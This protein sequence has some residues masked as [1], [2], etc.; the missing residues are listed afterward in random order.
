MRVRLALHSD[1]D[2][3]RLDVQ[4]GGRG[5]DRAKL[6]QADTALGQHIG[7]VGMQERIALLDGQFAITS[8]PSLGTPVV[9]E[10]PLSG[11]YTVDASAEETAQQHIQRV[12]HKARLVIADDHDVSRAGIRSM[13]IISALTIKVHVQHIIA[14]LGV[15]DRTQAAVRAI[16]LGL[17]G[18]NIS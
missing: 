11:M 14:K 7:L 5:F 3:I 4:D 9:A 12:S 6:N 15:S 10:T 16:E 2:N 18:E 17:L 8:A 13:L 1:E